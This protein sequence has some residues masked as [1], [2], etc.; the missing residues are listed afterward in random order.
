MKIQDLKLK[1]ITSLDKS[2]KYRRKAVIYHLYFPELVLEAI[3]TVLNFKDDFDIIFTIA[4]SLDKKLVELI[5][6]STLATIFICKNTGRDQRPWLTLL[7]NGYFDK[8]ELV[9]K[10]HGKRSLHRLDGDSW[11]Q[12]SI[13]T[14]CV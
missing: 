9:C 12:Y 2:F 13:A 10:L 4:E 14:L 8:Y 6:Q 1:K 11:R 7:Q 5:R 3:N